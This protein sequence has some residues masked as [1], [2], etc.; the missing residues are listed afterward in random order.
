[1]AAVYHGMD[2]QKV[3]AICEEASAGANSVVVAANYNC[4]GQLVISGH[5]TAV[6][7]A[8]LPS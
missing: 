1:M 3:A 4:P 5:E 6:D 2:D 8:L 7:R